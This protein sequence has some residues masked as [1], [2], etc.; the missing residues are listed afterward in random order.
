MNGSVLV[1]QGGGTGAYA[2]DRVLADSL[3]RALGADWEVQYPQ[4]PDEENCPYPEWKAE[5]DARLVSIKGSVALVGHSIGGSV[6]LKY[7]CD[8]PSPLSI[9][10]LFV[11]AAPYWGADPS[12]RWEEMALPADA[13]ARLAGDWPL[14]LYHSR[15]DEI[16]P[17]SHLAL[18]AAKLPRAA[19]REYDG[20]GHQFGDDLAD[21]AADIIRISNT[22]T[23]LK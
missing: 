15:D 11:V 22:Q 2:A 1:I 17:F 20:R 8:P 5:I 6:L 19:V 4:M 16:V 14:F 13:A 12:W 21:V 3:E 9:L 18:Y 10:G 7:L 23:A